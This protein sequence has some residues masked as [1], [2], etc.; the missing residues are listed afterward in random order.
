VAL[1]AAWYVGRVPG[2]VLQSGSTPDEQA[3]ALPGDELI[4]AGEPS[5]T[6]R[7]A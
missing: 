6:S 1:A 7:M 5:H 3:E 4:P 2:T